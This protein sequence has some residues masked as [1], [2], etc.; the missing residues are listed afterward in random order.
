MMGES[1]FNNAT[2]D[3]DDSAPLLCNPLHVAFGPFMLVN[4]IIAS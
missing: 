2:K 4:L 3:P 1:S